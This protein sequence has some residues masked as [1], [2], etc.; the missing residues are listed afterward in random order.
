M[1]THEALRTFGTGENFHAQ[2][3]FGFH[4][5]T[6]EGE[7]GYVFRVWAPNAQHLALIGE[8][9]NWQDNPIGMSCNE[10]GVW[11]VF[12]AAPQIGE[13]YK[14]LVTR[15]DGSV[16]EKIDPFAFGKT[17]YGWGAVSVLVSVI[18]QSIFTKCMPPRG[19]ST[20]TALHT[21]LLS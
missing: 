5:E 17:A 12:T 11:E 1:E 18:A 7:E 6:R 4:R 14:F 19:K 10:A 8:F 16:V 21:S 2:H 9:T 13:R 3:Y 20:K 15:A